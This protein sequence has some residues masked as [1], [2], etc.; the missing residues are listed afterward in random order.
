MQKLFNSI[1]KHGHYKGDSLFHP[2]FDRQHEKAMT[3]TEV[4]LLAGIKLSCKF[5]VFP[6]LRM[7]VVQIL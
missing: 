6:M 5:L 4:L 3:M 1:I 7:C 2:R